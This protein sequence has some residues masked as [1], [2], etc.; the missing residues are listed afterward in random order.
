M[1]S[2]I[3]TS[4]RRYLSRLPSDRYAWLVGFIYALL[5]FFYIFV[6]DHVLALIVSDPAQI[7]WLQTLKGWGFIVVTCLLLAH[8]VYHGRERARRA[9]AAARSSDTLYRQLIES[10]NDGVWVVAVGGKTTYVND[11]MAQMLGEQPHTLVGRD[12]R[13][14]ASHHLVKFVKESLP[15]RPPADALRFECEL[16][17]CDG[18]TISAMVSATPLT[19]ALGNLTGAMLMVTDITSRRNA[20]KTASR[21][22]ET[23]RLLLNE[24]DHR[25]RNNLS[26]L[27]SLIDLSRDASGNVREFAQLMSGRVQA[28]AKAHGL[29]GRVLQGELD[30]ERL[31]CEM[32]PGPHHQRISCSGPHVRVPAT[33]TISLALVVHELISRS[34]RTGALTSPG[35]R[36]E[37]RWS[38]ALREDRTV[39][40]DLTW[41]EFDGPRSTSR[42]ADGS[43]RQAANRE[44]AASD[45][46]VS[47]MVRS[48]LRGEIF[49]TMTPTGWLHHLRMVFDRPL[50]GQESVPEITTVKP[51]ALA[52]VRR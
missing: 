31:M 39:A 28:M 30:L 19:D 50:P 51:P 12:V 22:L 33:Q 49:S 3:P 34:E 10:T 46:L 24:L 5:G 16:H 27:A 14:F 25:V 18:G 11:T 2:R 40:L 15:G 38:A 4:L 45:Q 37:L 9:E 23:Q 48:D 52:S 43:G 26:S 41:Q 1:P 6:S 8:L 17:R 32:L 13:E 21:S 42:P 44:A 29:V 7:T 47:G 20:E 35:G 36:I